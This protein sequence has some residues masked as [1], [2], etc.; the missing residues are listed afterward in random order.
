M[1]WSDASRSP[2][3]YFCYLRFL[4][5]DFFLPVGFGSPEGLKGEGECSQ[6]DFKSAESQLSAKIYCTSPWQTGLMWDA[7]AVTP[8]LTATREIGY[9]VWVRWGG[10]LTLY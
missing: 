4:E 9:G 1:G 5:I 6:P 10:T 8:I 3:C 7:R 2:G